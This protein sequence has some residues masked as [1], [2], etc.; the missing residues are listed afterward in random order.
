LRRI[1]LILLLLINVFYIANFLI[2][3]DSSTTLNILWIVFFIISFCLSIFYLFRSR[4]NSGYN[5]YLLIAVL[6]ASIG[7]LGTFDYLY[8]ISNLMG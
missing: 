5:P 8:F 6:V 3:F 2:N 1:I 4:K 7:S